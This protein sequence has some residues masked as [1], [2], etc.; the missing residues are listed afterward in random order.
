MPGSFIDHVYI[1]LLG[2]VPLLL[3]LY[4]LYELVRSK[5]EARRREQE[6]ER[7]A[8]DTATAA[9][10]IVTLTPAPTTL[11]S[12]LDLAD[13]SSD[14]SVLMRAPVVFHNTDDDDDEKNDAS[15]GVGSEPAP[16]SLPTLSPPP[17]T[18]A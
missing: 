14:D 1:G 7:S 13:N 12:S 16:Q 4:K 8:P 17:T 5:W 2:S 3:G 9:I 10:P 15:I 11:V 18:L 6:E